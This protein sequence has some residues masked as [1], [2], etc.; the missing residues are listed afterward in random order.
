MGLLAAFSVEAQKQSSAA[1]SNIAKEQAIASSRV[2]VIYDLRDREMARSLSD[3]HGQPSPDLLKVVEDTKR[4][5]IDLSD[6]TIP[7]HLRLIELAQLDLVDGV[8][9]AKVTA[10][11]NENCDIQSGFGKELFEDKGRQHALAMIKCSREGIDHAQAAMHNAN[12]LHES[13]IAKL[14]L[15]PYTQ[16]KWL[17]QAR[18]STAMQDADLKA[19]YAHWRITYQA[20]EDWVRFLDNHANAFHV[21]NNVLVF[22]NETDIGAAHELQLKVADAVAGFGH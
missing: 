7:L 17:A 4:R 5:T 9:A 11:A 6:A 22:T 16:S 19:T 21:E 14:K 20:L 1:D 12:K 10:P 2:K 18:E 15:P 13:R 3:Q 8:A